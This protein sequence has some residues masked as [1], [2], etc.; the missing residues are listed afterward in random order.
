MTDAT[1]KVSISTRL[2]AV[3]RRARRRRRATRPLTAELIA[4]GRSNLTYGD[5]RRRARTWVLRRPPLGHV[6]AD[7]ARHGPRVPRA[8]RA[9]RHRR[10]R[11]RAR[12]ALCEDTEVNGA[13]FYVMERVDGRILRDAPTT[14]RRSRPSEARRRAP[15]SSSTCSPASTRSTTRRSASATSAA[16]TASSSA[17]S[18]AGASSGSDRRP[19]ELPAIDE[20]ARRLDARAPRVGPAH[21]RARRLPARQH[22]AGA[23]RPGRR[24][25]PCST[26]RC[27]RSATRS[28]TSACS[29]STG[30]TS[31]AQIDR[32]RRR[33][34]TPEPGLP[35]QGRGRRALRQRSAGARSTHLDFYVVFALYKLAIIVEGIHA[36][37]LM[38]KT[39]GEGFERHGRR[40]VDDARRRGH[41][42]S[43]TPAPSPRSR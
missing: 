19:R 24:S 23:R 26:G 31:A 6:L 34:S 43:P 30:A 22:D 4:G 42:P 35:H 32:H 36:R 2:R 10:A 28:P 11:S 15:T 9:R 12:Y 13:P 1:P 17:R 5:L 29:S 33:R 8:H 20:L 27:R 21:D 3:L 7:R 41:R 39:L 16:P 40:C 38:G 25:S 14:R 37:F 18:A